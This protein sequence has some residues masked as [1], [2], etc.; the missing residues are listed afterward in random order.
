MKFQR[1]LITLALLA[2][3]MV[4]R[5]CT[6]EEVPAPE[7]GRK[8]FLGKW[9]VSPVKLTYEVNIVEDPNSSDG[10]FIQNFALI[11]Y[12]FPPASAVING[13]T[14][15]LDPDQVIGSGLTV[16]GSGVLSGNRIVWNYTTFD[17]A[18]LTQVTE[19][20]TRQ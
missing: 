16:N 7:T 5:S 8:A 4:F 6:D 19:V 10:V 1:I 15:V 13:S 3:L 2:S 11:G 18:D 17:G 9:N 12:S 14:I 20:Y